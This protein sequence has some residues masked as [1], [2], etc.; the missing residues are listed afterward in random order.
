MQ[1]RDYPILASAAAKAYGEFRLA[2][3]GGKRTSSD[4]LHEFYSWRRF[5][6]DTALGEIA[7]FCAVCNQVIENEKPWTLAKKSANANQLEA[8]LYGWLSPCA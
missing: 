4:G 1:R 5:R 8:V 3:E 7:K 2:I 6:I